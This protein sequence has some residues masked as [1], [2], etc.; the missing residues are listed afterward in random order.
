M[1][2]E[3]GNVVTPWIFKLSHSH[4]TC[5]ARNKRLN[6]AVSVKDLG[7]RW[8]SAEPGLLTEASPG[9]PWDAGE[10]TR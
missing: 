6:A 2:G 1:I 10:P 7:Q 5:Q 4:D 3:I 9:E 8:I